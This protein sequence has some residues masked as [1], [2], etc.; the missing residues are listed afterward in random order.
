MLEVGDWEQCVDGRAASAGAS[1]YA[2]F[3]GVHAT[4]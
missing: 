2:G 3:V 4:D 1:Y